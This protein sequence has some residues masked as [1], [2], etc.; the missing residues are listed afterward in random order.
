MAIK[1]K[2]VDNV[3]VLTLGGKLMGGSETSDIRD[4]VYSLI[5]DNIT[6]VVIDL[7][8]VKWINSSGLGALMACHTSQ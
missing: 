5:S 8:K 7:K 6:N 3:A 1:E 2:I 4:K